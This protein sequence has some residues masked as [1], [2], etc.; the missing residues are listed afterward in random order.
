MTRAAV[1]ILRELGRILVCQRKKSSRYPL[2]WEF[3][4]GKLELGE[5]FQDCLIRELREELSID[6]DSI[7]RIDTQVSRYDDGGE[8]EV[9]Y[10]FVE[11]FAGTPTNNVFEEIRWVTLTELKSLDVL[12]GNKSVIER[13]EED[14]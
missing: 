5:T 7:E 14:M 4:G 6:V 1:A 10:C 2:K 13:M 12:E 8:F 3:P 11:H 9:A